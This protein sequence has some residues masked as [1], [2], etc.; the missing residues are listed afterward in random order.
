[1][2][3]INCNDLHEKLLNIV[4]DLTKN[5]ICTYT[6]IESS[7]SE[8]ELREIYDTNI[9][10]LEIVLGNIIDNLTKENKQLKTALKGI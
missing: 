10:N 3:D 8:A 7:S 4:N 2:A 9:K 6:N 5:G 1:M